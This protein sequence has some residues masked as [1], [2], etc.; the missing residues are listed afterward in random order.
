MLDVA[1]NG[2]IYVNG[3]FGEW[4][5]ADTQED[6]DEVVSLLEKAGRDQFILAVR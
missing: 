1:A 4:I 6:E 2:L 3:K 5:E